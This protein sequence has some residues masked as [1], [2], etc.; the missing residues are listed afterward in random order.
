MTKRKGCLDRHPFLIKKRPV[1]TDLFK[2]FIFIFEKGTGN[3]YGYLT[4]IPFQK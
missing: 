1:K 4:T 3:K 2:V